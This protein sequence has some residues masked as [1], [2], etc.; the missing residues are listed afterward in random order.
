MLYLL[1]KRVS[2]HIIVFG[3]F[4]N[5]I[6]E[7]VSTFLRRLGFVLLFTFKGPLSQSS[8]IFSVAFEPFIGRLA[9]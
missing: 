4:L 5:F 2:K 7:V 9:R 8:A 6:K 1:F 3:L